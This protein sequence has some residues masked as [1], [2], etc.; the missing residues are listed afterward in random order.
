MVVAVCDKFG[1]C[2]LVVKLS[3]VA[4]P[5]NGRHEISRAARKLSITAAGIISRV[6]SH[7]PQAGVR[8]PE[9]TMRS[10]MMVMM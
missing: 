2:A 7:M 3:A 8:V 9:R 6:P 5:W 4:Q 1:E 10:P